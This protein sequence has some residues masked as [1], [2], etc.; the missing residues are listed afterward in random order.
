MADTTTTNLGLTKP[1]VGGSTNTWGT[2]LNSDLDYIDAMFAKAS[3]SVT[4]HVNN[5]NISGS[6]YKLDQ[7]KMGDDRPLQFGAAPDYWLI[8]DSSNTQFELN[9]TNVDGGGTDGVVFSVSDG[10]DDVAFTGKIST[11][12]ID[13]LAE[14]DL[15]LQDA[16]GGEYVGFDAPATVSGSYTL[17]LPAAVG[18]SG[19]ILRTSDGSGTLEWVTDQEGDI[20]EVVAGAGLTGGGAGPGAVTLNA[21]GTSNRITVNADDI[22]IASTY[23]GQT[24]ITT[25]G[26]IATGVWNGTAITGDYIDVTTSPLANTKIWIGDSSGDAQEFALSGD[27]TM[28]AGGAVTVADNAITLAKLEDGTQ[29]D[30]LYYGASG[31][32]ARLGA[33]SSGQVLTSGGAGANPAWATPTTGDITSV[34]AGTGLSGGGTSGDV[35][36]NVDAAQTQITSVGALNAGSITSGFGAIDVGSSAISGG[37]GTLSSLSVGD[38]NITNVGDIALDSI[39]SDGS[40]IA[41]GGTGDTVTCNGAWIF[42]ESSADVDF[43]IEGNGEAN[44]FFVDAGNDRIGINTNAPT[45]KLHLLQSAADFDSGIKLVGS[46]SVV[47]GRI[48]MG[49]SHLHVDNATAGTGTGLTL[50]DGGNVG[51]G[52]DAPHAKLT[53]KDATNISMDSSG[54]GQLAVTGNGYTGAIALDSGYMNIYHNSSS[55]G[56]AFGTNETGRMYIDSAGIVTIGR[57][58]GQAF[59]VTGHQFYQSGGYYNAHA[60]GEVV[61]WYESGSGNDVG[62]IDTTSSSTAYNTSSDRRLKK[63]IEAADASGSLIDDIEI[64]KHDWIASDDYVRYG[65]IAQDLFEV[66][67]EA[68]SRGTDGDLVDDDVSDSEIPTKQVW[69]V[70]YSKLVPLLVKEVQDLRTRVLELESGDDGA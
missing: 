36:L 70:D 57:T 3:T 46:D 2:K 41:I 64:V 5:Q 11:A 33:G 55:A 16:S 17:T 26:T 21:V 6:S 52:V 48:W 29:G 32:P 28:T 49:G 45:A 15:R 27:V 38:G 8:Y 53:V 22:D 19:Q 60:A 35:T 69:G 37:A 42:N 23:V 67:P 18:S 51:V 47:S 44:L 59:T 43:R 13:I 20:T 66:V 62:S 68:V 58:S 25:L 12:Q 56:I 7:I 63:N 30:V 14:G 24:S 9:S 65:V 54:S 40:A 61:R 1:E 31:A 50:E 39:S 10:T 34:V 4:F